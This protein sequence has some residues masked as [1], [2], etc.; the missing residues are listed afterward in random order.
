MSFKLFSTRSFKS[1]FQSI[2]IHFLTN[3]EC[4]KDSVHLP[5]TSGFG[6]WTSGLLILLVLWTSGSSENN[7]KNQGVL[8]VSAENKIY[9]QVFASV[10]QITFCKRNLQVRNKMS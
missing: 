4:D 7:L 1:N 5:Q 6:Q 8:N 10:K 9:S 2:L 3:A